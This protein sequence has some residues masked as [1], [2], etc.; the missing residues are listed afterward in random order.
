MWAEELDGRMRVNTLS[1]KGRTGLVERVAKG[2][3]NGGGGYWL[4]KSE[5][6]M[7]DKGD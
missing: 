6:R 1:L 4:Y 3:A 7:V 2:E 5:G